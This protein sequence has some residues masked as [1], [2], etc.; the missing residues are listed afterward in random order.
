MQIRLTITVAGNGDYFTKVVS[1]DAVPRIGEMIW[2]YEPV[3]IE[4]LVTDVVHSIPSSTGIVVY[5][6][7]AGIEHLAADI[8]RVAAL[9]PDEER[10][11]LGDGWFR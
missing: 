5:A 10:L 8:D 3:E 11:L 6:D 7:R 2:L 1:M 9:T 4:C